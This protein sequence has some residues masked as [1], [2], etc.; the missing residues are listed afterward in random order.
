MEAVYPS[1]EMSGKSV[2]TRRIQETDL[3]VVATNHMLAFPDSVLTKLGSE[4]VRRYYE[5]QLIGPHEISARAAFVHDRL[6]GFCFAGIFRGAMGGFLKRNRAYLLFRVLTHPWLITNPIFRERLLLGT[7]V[8]TRLRR[9]EKSRATS[10]RPSQPAFGV[11]SIGTHPEYQGLGVG[12]RL[13]DEAEDFA[14]SLGFSEIHLS[15][16]TNN[17]QA[18]RFYER[19]NWTKELEASGWLGSMKKL[20]TL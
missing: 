17:E 11:L 3:V 20:I 8:L 19:Q 4:A 18:I 5:W 2:S 7:R 13:M 12:K 14:R 10:T 15:V 1:S 16:S 9:R 6:V